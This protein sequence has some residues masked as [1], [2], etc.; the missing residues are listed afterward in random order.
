MAEQSDEREIL[1]EML[2]AMARRAV[3]QRAEHRAE[4][5]DMVETFS[6]LHGEINAL[7]HARHGAWR[8]WRIVH[9]A[10]NRAYVLGLISGSGVDWSSSCRSCLTYIGWRG[11]RPYVL[12]KPRD[13]WFCL[14]VGHHI[15]RET[16]HESGGICAVCAPC[17]VCGSPDPEHDAWACDVARSKA[18]KAAG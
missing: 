17:W 8:R 11:R 18:A 13:W 4:R 5:L 2:R 1:S 16:C 6:H 7:R 15:R 3:A 14:L 12:G 9:R 10:T